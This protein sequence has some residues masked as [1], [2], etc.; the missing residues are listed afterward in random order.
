MSLLQSSMRSHGP[1]T[2]DVWTDTDSDDVSD[3]GVQS[4]PSSDSDVGIH[5]TKMVSLLHKYNGA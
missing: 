3:S 4:L 1:D 2:R 5:D